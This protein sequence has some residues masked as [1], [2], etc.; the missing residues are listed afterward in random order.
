MYPK[1]FPLQIREILG[2][3]DPKFDSNLQGKLTRSQNSVIWALIYGI[4]SVRN[5][6]LK[7]HI[8]CASAIME[9]QRI[10]QNGF[11]WT[12]DPNIS[13]CTLDPKKPFLWIWSSNGWLLLEAIHYILLKYYTSWNSLAQIRY[14]ITCKDGFG[15]LS[16]AKYGRWQPQNYFLS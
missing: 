12:S 15:E 4:W 10:C 11:F 1:Q 3:L 16:L 8:F 14:Q 6:F 13:N 5:N 2:V 7:I 9:C